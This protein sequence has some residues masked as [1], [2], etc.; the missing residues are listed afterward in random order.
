MRIN[1]EGIDL[2]RG[3]EGLELAAYQDIAGIWTIGYGHTGDDVRP[4]KKISEGE[5]N[6]LLRQDLAR[7]ERGVGD[8]VRVP[9]NSNEFSALV[10]F[11]YNVGL[12]GLRRSTTLRTLN[13]EDR[14][15]AADAMTWWDKATIRGKKRSIPG[16]R[17]RRAAERGLFL[18]PVE[19]AQPAN[20]DVLDSARIS[21]D[22]EAPRRHRLRNSRTLQGA[23]GATAAGAG[24]TLLGQDQARR[25]QM[26]GV[27]AT[28]DDAPAPQGPPV[29]NAPDSETAMVAPSQSMNEAAP[30]VSPAP[31]NMQETV[32]SVEPPPPMSEAERGEIYEQ[33][34]FVFALLMALSI[35]YIVWARI[36]DWRHGE[37]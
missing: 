2:I 23:G 32:E 26:D 24:S 17:R 4:G 21:P 6:E 22:E 11:A 9:L 20:D 12:T 1:Q 10:S 19:R 5:A 28:A 37:R 29:V 13:R 15:S 34:F 33:L 35:A 30:T 16:L 25:D 31:Q 14:L 18:K 27:P 36:D 7:F 3:F 8:L